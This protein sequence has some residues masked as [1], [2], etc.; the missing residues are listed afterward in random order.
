MKCAS[1]VEMQLTW[2]PFCFIMPNNKVRFWVPQKVH[3]NIPTDQKGVVP[4][5]IYWSKFGIDF[6]AE[7]LVWRALL[8]EAPSSIWPCPPSH[9][10]LRPLFC[11]HPH[12]HPH[13][14]W[15]AGSNPPVW[16]KQN[17]WLMLD[18]WR[19][20]PESG[21]QMVPCTEPQGKGSQLV[22]GK[23]QYTPTCNAF[24]FSTQPL[25]CLSY[26]AVQCP[27]LPHT[28]PGSVLC[29]CLKY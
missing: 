27:A 1:N 9:T 19:T 21:S 14:S 13:S 11:R 6:S 16:G 12:R 7:G 4:L 2:N 8:E 26:T 10:Y 23:Q 5:S 20:D 3:V 18:S 25:Y 22:W 15:W 24:S 29:E 17:V 28:R